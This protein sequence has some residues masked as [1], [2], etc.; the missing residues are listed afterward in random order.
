MQLTWIAYKDAVFGP[1]YRLDGLPKPGDCA[2]ARRQGNRR[3]IANAFIRDRYL[4]H[5]A[6]TLKLAICRLEAEIDRRSIGLLGVDDVTF[7]T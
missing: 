2:V 5:T 6:P 7:T 3:F 4:S 1:A